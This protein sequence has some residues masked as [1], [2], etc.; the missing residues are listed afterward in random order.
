MKTLNDVKLM[1]ETLMAKQFTFNTYHGVYTLSGN[2]LGYQ[3]KFDNAKRRFG[4]CNYGKKFISLSMPLC[5][6][7]LDK[8][9]T[10]ITDT[11]LH[12]LAHAFCVHVYGIRNGR[13]HDYN[14]Q[15]IAKQ[16]GCNGERCFDSSNVNM[17]K[18]KYTLLCEKCGKQTP[19]HKAVR[20]VVACGKCCKEHNNG[21]FS[22][23]YQLKLVTNY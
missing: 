6:E 20:R 17:P 5:S 8:V 1:A 12:E 16:I 9:D 11:M 23:D 19:K 21:Q 4:C 7:N 14:W 2:Q 18:A 22:Y 15:H 13:G 3:F 10:E